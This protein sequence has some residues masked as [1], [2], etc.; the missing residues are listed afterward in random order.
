MEEEG[1]DN[2]TMA[3]KTVKKGKRVLRKDGTSLSQLEEDLELGFVEPAVPKL[4]EEMK[5]NVL[6]MAPPKW[7]LEDY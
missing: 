6:S 4:F 2:E 5:T 1:S 3:K 7:K